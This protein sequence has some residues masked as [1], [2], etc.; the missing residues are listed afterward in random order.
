MVFSSKNIRILS[1]EHYKLLLSS[2]TC[3]LQRNNC[4]GFLCY[5]FIY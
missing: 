1:P 4:F 5:C 3:R 2:V